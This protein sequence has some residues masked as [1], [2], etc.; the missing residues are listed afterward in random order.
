MSKALMRAL[1]WLALCAAAAAVFAPVLD[2]AVYVGVSDF[3]WHARVASDWAAGTPPSTPH[4]LFQAL[5]IGLAPLMPGLDWTGRAV[6][7]ALA[8]QAALAAVVTA[9]LREVVPLRREGARFAA[10]AALALGVMLAAPVHFTTWSERNLYHGYLGLA[11]YHNPTLILLKPLAV[12]LWWEAS[13]ALAGSA[14]PLGLFVLLTLASAFA[15]P[16]H[17]IALLPAAAALASGLAWAGRPPA[18]RSLLLGLALPAALALA[19]QLAFYRGS[20]VSFVWAPLTAMAYRDANLAGRFVLSALFPLAV[21]AAFPRAFARDAGLA[22][23]GAT[24]ATG[25]AY[26]YLLA[27]RG[28]VLAARNFAWSAQAALFVLFVAA[29]RTVL[30]QVRAGGRWQA[31]RLAACAIAWGLHLSCGLYFYRHPTWW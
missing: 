20:G 22:L 2:T 27:E 17:L 25:A 19:W 16:S 3:K 5:L 31:P 7:L 23:A 9:L 26:A 30:Q 15:K 4:F 29:T 6:Q 18:W 1:P 12:L 10:A 8:C 11:V 14:R 28:G 13:R 21:L 24:F